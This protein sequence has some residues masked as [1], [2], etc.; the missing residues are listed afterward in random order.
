MIEIL[1]IQP[2][3]NERQQSLHNFGSDKSDNLKLISS[4]VYIIDVS[5]AFIGKMSVTRSLH[6]VQ[7]VRKQSVDDC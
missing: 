2:W 4:L 1:W 5:A 6:H 3:Q 7:N